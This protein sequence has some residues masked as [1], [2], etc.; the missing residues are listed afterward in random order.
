MPLGRLNNTTPVVSAQGVAT[1]QEKLPTDYK[2]MVRSDNQISATVRLPSAYIRPDTTA[3][4]NRAARRFGMRYL[5]ARGMIRM[6]LQ[7][8]AA[9]AVQRPYIS[10]FQPDM[11]GPIHDAGFNDGLFQAGYPGFNLGLSFKV[12]NIEDNAQQ[13]RPTTGVFKMT[14]ITQKLL[15]V[16][17]VT[18]KPE[19]E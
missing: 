6:P 9:S 16:G 14:T 17:R 3:V 7:P 1:P 4:V 2:A 5:Y 8:G 13:P 18:G 12:A 19:G 11:Q 10:G 15:R